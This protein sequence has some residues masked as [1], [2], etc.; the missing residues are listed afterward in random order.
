MGKVNLRPELFCLGKIRKLRPV[1]HGNCLEYL[2]EKRLSELLTELLH[3]RIDRLAGLSGNADCEV[4][5]CFLFQQSQ[6]NRLPAIAL[7]N[8]CI[9]FPVTNLQPGRCNLGPLVYGCSV[10]FLRLTVLLQH[11]FRF[12]ASESSSGSST[13]LPAHTSL[14]R[15]LVQTISVGRNS[16]CFR[17]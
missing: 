3:R 1:V 2:A 7:P 9:T 11:F 14:Y 10:C 15:V 12:K 5:L 13:R 16:L 4:V 6:N 17:A 8:H